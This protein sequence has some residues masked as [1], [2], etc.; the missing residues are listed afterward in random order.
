MICRDSVIAMVRRCGKPVQRPVTPRRTYQT[1][2]KF[3][4][5]LELFIDQGSRTRRSEHKA[6]VVDGSYLEAHTGARIHV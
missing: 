6:R 2:H 5:N 1:N 3:S 4:F